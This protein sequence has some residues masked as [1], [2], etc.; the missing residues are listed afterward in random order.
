MEKA[1]PRHRRER[2]RKKV[3]SLKQKDKRGKRK[4]SIKEVL[5]IYNVHPDIIDV[6][7]CDLG[8]LNP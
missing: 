1:G 3:E 8:M 4:L 6:C 5:Y 2:E 7:F